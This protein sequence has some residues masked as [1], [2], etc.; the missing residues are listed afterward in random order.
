M[1]DSMEEIFDTVKHTALVHKTGGGTGF[2]FS[3]LRPKGD[4]VMA[5][6]G[7]ASG[8]IS[9]MTVLDAATNVIKQGGKRR[10]ANMGVLRVDHPDILDF[11][12][13]KEREGIL[14]NF[15]ISVA[16]TDKFMDAVVND[17][18]W[19]LIVTMAWKTADPGVLFI[20]RMNQGPSNPVPELGPIETTNPCGEQP[21]YPYDS[22]NLGSINLSKMVRVNDDGKP[23]ID[24]GRLQ[25]TVRKGVHFLDNVIDA[26]RYPILEI[27]LMTKSIRRI[28]LGVMGW[29]D[30]LIQ[31]GIPYNS[32]TALKL[33]ETLM[34]F[35]TE[36]GRKTSVELAK[37]RGSFP[38]FKGSIWEKMGYECMRNATVTTIAPTGTIGV[39]ACVSSGIE[40][41][42]AVA[43][44]RNV[45]ESLGVGKNLIEINPLFE[46]SAIKEGFYSEELMRRA[47]RGWSIQGLAEIPEQTR[48]IFVTAHDV[49]PEWHVR[50]QG[51]FQKYTDNAV[52]KT[53]NFPFTAT[54][55]DVEKAYMLAYQLGCK[56]ITIYR[57]GS[58]M[59][60]VITPV[61]ETARASES[62]S[63]FEQE[64]EIIKVPAEFS[65]G[66]S[67]CG[68]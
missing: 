21:L 45:G 24:W 20:D 46:K 39:I 31:L 51:A 29:A 61:E 10:G 62:S 37:E 5:T 25:Q 42:F 19:N 66:C 35:I 1:G 67:T 15:N 34:R 54:P 14:S 16:I 17:K 9:F 56:G 28:G 68:G 32:M 48:K 64:A 36:E 52:S 7:V 27:E 60:Q 40:P 12:V 58:K 65:G 47:S 63:E 8:P 22:C 4:V 49:S 33:A 43:Y 6:G 11:I 3:R 57:D 38:R 13:C 59:V 2:S 23:E 30:M 50:M 18:E 41:L 44:M 26:N 55:Y 53:I